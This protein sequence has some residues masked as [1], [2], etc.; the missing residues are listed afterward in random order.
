MYYSLKKLTSVLI[1]LTLILG[2]CGGGSSSSPS[3][4]GGGTTVSGTPISG[5]V[6][7]PANSVVQIDRESGIFYVTLDFFMSSAR[8]AVTGLFPVSNAIVELIRIDDEGIQVGAV[9]AT[10]TTD[11]EG[12]YNLNLPEG[13]EPAADLVV[14][15]KGSSG[16]AVWR[17]IVSAESV[18]IDPLSQFILDSLI[19][20]PGLILA[21]I[22]IATVRNLVTEANARARRAS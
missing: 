5:K 3:D 11:S 10:T 19:N 4:D 13:V 17:A 9:L 8:A 16:Q 20:E 21:N 12:A 2:A 14:Q 7:A 22:N 18:D 6:R 1:G 15:I